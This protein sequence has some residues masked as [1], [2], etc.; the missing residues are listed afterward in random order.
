MTAQ[1]IQAFLKFLG[2]GVLLVSEEEARPVALVTG[3]NIPENV[4]NEIAHE[5]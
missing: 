3:A 4:F 2:R 5:P 1:A